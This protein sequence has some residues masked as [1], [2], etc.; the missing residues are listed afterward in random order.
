MDTVATA[1]PTRFGKYLLLDKLSIGGMAEIWRAKMFGTEGF[2]QIIAV[3]RILPDIA[4]DREFVTMFINEA[5]ITAQLTHQNVAQIFEL[6]H[7]GEAYFIAMEYIG[8]KDL[9]ALFEYS[10]RRGQ[11]LPIPL[12]CYVI[13]KV[14]EG[15]AYAHQKKDS[16]GNAMN[17][18]HRD[19]SPQNVLIGYDGQVKVID[20]GIAKASG[21]IKT[22]AGILKGKFSYMSPEQAEGAALDRR[23][24]IFSMGV[25]L[26][27]ILTG[28]RL[29]FGHSDFL[30]L[31][32]VQKMEMPPPTLYNPKIPSLLN[33][34]VLKALAR[35]SRQRYQDASEMA[36][37]LRAVL[38]TLASAVDETQVARFM[39]MHFA[40]DIKVEKELLKA[41][42]SIEAPPDQ[43]LT[44][45]QTFLISPNAAFSPIGAKPKLT[46]LGSLLGNQPRRHMDSLQG[47]DDGANTRSLHAPA[48]SPILQS[49]RSTSS[50]TSAERRGPPQ[51]VLDDGPTR[52]FLAPPAP[53]PSFSRKE[54]VSVVTSPSLT[55][56]NLLLPMLGTFSVL[57][58]ILGLAGYGYRTLKQHPTGL[59]RMTVTTEPVD[60]EIVVNARVLKVEGNPQEIQIQS[61]PRNSEIDLEVRHRGYASFR[62][63]IYLPAS[64]Q[65]L[66]IHAQLE[67]TR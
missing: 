56:P 49:P 63:K 17:V 24:D 27:E 61:F 4:R 7:V 57:L 25:C 54:A 47:E 53:A 1:K 9:R 62:Q 35:D 51:D 60:A 39:E 19:I 45:E 67:L 10:L 26:H 58:V 28:R 14:C 23:S 44:L 55:R 34:V 50:S 37:D 6:G 48:W 31:E 43:Q 46:A 40:E 16:A 38:G 29:F 59:A 13:M 52:S 12:S 42:Q 65:P 8:G 21:Q 41:Y 18:V 33:K 5:K 20:F 11:L 64:E 2:E 32:K 36:T 30:I 3:K 15:L 66:R 22:E